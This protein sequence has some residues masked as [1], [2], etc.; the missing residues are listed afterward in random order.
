[1]KN[2][3]G[4]NL[5]GGRILL[6]IRVG[7][8]LLAIG[9]LMPWA[10]CGNIETRNLS[11]TVVGSGAVSSDPW[12]ID[13]GGD[14]QGD[15]LSGTEVTLTAT[16]EDGYELESW[17]GACSGTAGTCDVTLT[18]DRV[19]TATFTES[20]QESSMPNGIP[21]PEFGISEV[22]PDHPMGWPSSEVADYYY[23][24]A[25]DPNATDSSNTYGYPDKPR[26]YLPNGTYGAGT[27]VELHGD[28]TRTM[29]LT[30]NGTA[31]NPCWLRGDPDD[32]PQLSGSGRV[33]IR[34]SSY[35]I[36]ENLE[37]VDKTGGMIGI[38]NLDDGISHHIGV[39]NNYAHDFTYASPG[40]VMGAIARDSGETHDIVFYN[41]TF[42]RIGDPDATEDTDLHLTVFSLRNGSQ[43][44]AS[45][46]RLW[47]LNNVGLE[48]GGSGIQVNGWVG[49]QSNLHHV[50]IGNNYGENFRQRFIGVKQSSHVIISENDS[51]PG[52]N[53]TAGN[54]SESLGWALGPDYVWF[55]N[56]NVSDGGDGFRSSDSSGGSVDTTRIFILGNKISNIDPTVHD[57]YYV[58]TNDWRHGQGVNLMNDRATVYAVDNTFDDIF[59][60]IKVTKSNTDV[61]ICGNIFRNKNPEDAFVGFSS[62]AT[63]DGSYVDN[64]IYLND[65]ETVTDLSTGDSIFDRDF[66]SDFSV[67]WSH[68]E[69][70]S[71]TKQIRYGAENFYDSLDDIEANGRPSKYDW[72]TA[73]GDV[74][75]LFYELYGIRLD[76][77][78]SRPCG[79]DD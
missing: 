12:G 63:L 53:I 16:P 19:V 75:D 44:T 4:R 45:A 36:V 59:G 18:E 47:W 13:C 5:D 70:M 1:M 72:I 60:G 27:Y 48:G 26:T 69:E 49:G 43:T 3:K 65:N 23:I 46:Y 61:F 33:S 58:P 28:V 10:G 73:T 66:R 8:M 30:F 78:S 41:N 55:I 57:L 56:N 24:D 32:M 39:R 17:G 76:H 37:G 74:Y 25:S 14:C 9:A 35:L 54:V 51:I 21:A 42:E 79:S 6:C 68:L 31:E 71:D 77:V 38:T 20:G 64:N 34:N 2:E 22:A 52:R 15:F 40:A 50:Y 7:L 67:D 29:Y 62:S 11:V